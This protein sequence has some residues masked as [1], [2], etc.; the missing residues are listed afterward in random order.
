[1]QTWLAEQNAPGEQVP[2]LL[3]ES[4]EVQALPSSQDA[5]VVSRSQGWTSV[6]LKGEP[7]TP[8]RQV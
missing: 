6:Q 2:E 7:Q 4:P 5:P 1:V 3:Q 8:L